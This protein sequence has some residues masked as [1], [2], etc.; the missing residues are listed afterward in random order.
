MYYL[1]LFQNHSQYN[2][3]AGGGMLK[4]NVSHCVSE[5]E[6]HYNPIN[7]SKEYFT[8]EPI[9]DGTFTISINKG[10]TTNEVR[11]ISYSLD[12][13]ETWVKTDN[14]D[15]QIVTI[16]TP[17][18]LNK[19]K[20]LLK[21]DADSLAYSTGATTTT[22]T[23]GTGATII[24][25]TCKF[26]AMGNVMSLLFG[27]EFKDKNTLPNKGL[28]FCR[29]FYANKN[30]ISAKN[31]SMPATSATVNCCNRMFSSCSNLLTAPKLPATTLAN[32]CYSGMFYGCTSLATAPELPA[33]TL[34]QF[35]YS[36]MFSG[37]TSLETA[38]SILP[39]TTLEES[40]YY[41][42]FDG[43]TSLT[44]VPELPATTLAIRCYREMF[45]GCTNLTTAPELPATA[46]A[47][48]CYIYMFQ[49]CTSL[50]TAPELPAATLK[51]QCYYGM[52]ESC[53]S[54]VK[55][56]SELPATTLVEDCYAQMF[57]GCKKL[58]TAPELPATSLVKGCYSQMFHGCTSLEV[59]PELPA[60]SLV[61]DCYFQ[62]FQGCTNLNYIKA[63]FTT[64]PSGSSPNYYTANWVDG[65]AA[66]G[67][68][69]KNAAAT[70]DVSGANGI[71][72]GWTIQTATA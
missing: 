15:N 24:G 44:T 63:M 2:E 67:T 35:C 41:G 71:P 49:R 68:F 11:S 51:Y 47:D 26:N 62:M 60:T 39:A 61:K 65:V 13:G 17:T 69:V 30:L 33:T 46:L 72:T 7:Y 66:S 59:A 18:V 10:V 32:S 19:Q 56:P 1:K 53:A 6:V 27:D 50:T 25:S 57:W 48:N 40:C 9:E 22:L 37:C 8:L 64:T 45:Q 34:A 3:F 29:L 12:N 36:Y 16:T 23:G 52:F 4:P 21:G 31:L 70:W 28:S 38:P 58:A 54:L 43:C 20:V 5:N 55:S 42:M 14:I